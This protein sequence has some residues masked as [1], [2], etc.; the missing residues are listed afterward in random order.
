V[1][2]GLLVRKSGWLTTIKRSKAGVGG[3]PR[4]VGQCDA[5]KARESAVDYFIANF[6]IGYTFSGLLAGYQ[7]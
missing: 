7:C 4:L 1:S 3:M 5:R 6:Q 2:R